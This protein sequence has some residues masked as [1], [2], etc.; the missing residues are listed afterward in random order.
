MLNWLKKQINSSSVATLDKNAVLRV[1]GDRQ[2]GKT[3]YMASLAYWPNANPGS[4][5]Q[6]VNPIG[7]EGEQLVAQAQNILEQGLAMESTLPVADETE[8]K[9]YMLSISLKQKFSKD[10]VELNINCKDYSGELFSDLIHRPQDP[11]L[12]VYLEDCLEGSGILFLLDGT[13]HRKDGEYAQGLE[14]FLAALD[15]VD[16]D[17][18]Q[19]RIAFALGKCEQPELWVNRH[20]PRKLVEMR[21]AKVKRVLYNW[22]EIGCLKLDYFATSAFGMLGTQY[23]EPNAR[24]LQK[25]RGGTRSVLKDPKRWRPF[26]LVA[27]IYWLCTGTRHKQL[28]DD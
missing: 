25:D 11:L 23:P 28:E 22:A 19:R 20:Q 12:Q 10:N 13:A 15:R 1:I 7:E 26:G 2:S 6:R 9:N 16:L 4:P 21:F 5:V 18:Q 8:L 27:P 17:G 3:T 14:K 24:K